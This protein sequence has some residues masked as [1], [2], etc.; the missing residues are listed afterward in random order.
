M[1]K[2]AER[3]LTGISEY[4]DICL[5]SSMKIKFNVCSILNSNLWVETGNVDTDEKG[6]I[7][8]FDTRAQ[9]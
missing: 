6:M 5:S 9:F 7:A 2:E 1:C 3:I 4:I 8:L